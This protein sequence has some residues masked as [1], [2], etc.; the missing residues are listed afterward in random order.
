MELDDFFLEDDDFAE[1]NEL[2]IL[3][4]A[5]LDVLKCLKETVEKI[6]TNIKFKEE[7]EETYNLTVLG[8]YMDRLTMIYNTKGSNQSKEELEE[9]L[10]EITRITTPLTFSNIDKVLPDENE[11]D[12]DKNDSAPNI[13]DSGNDGAG[14]DW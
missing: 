5:E 10:K 9:T 8:N 6:E 7:S 14:I 12:H 3:D 13:T 1:E 4:S 2:T 11:E